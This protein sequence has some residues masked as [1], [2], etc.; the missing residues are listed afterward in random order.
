[1]QW[2]DQ[3]RFGLLIGLGL[4]L[5]GIPSPMLWGIVAMLLPIRS[6][7]RRSDRRGRSGG[8]GDCR[9]PGLVNA[10]VDDRVIC[11]RRASTWVNSP[12]YQL[13]V[14]GAPTSGGYGQ[15]GSSPATVSSPPTV[16]SPATACRCWAWPT[17]ASTR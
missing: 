11:S 13:P 15:Y 7:H 10:A 5:I 12:T 4:Y 9:R 16:S 8:F 2:A 17:P 6:L 1:M 3:R 14:S